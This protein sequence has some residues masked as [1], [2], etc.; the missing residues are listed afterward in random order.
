M[1][2]QAHFLVVEIVELLFGAVEHKVHVLPL[3]RALT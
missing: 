3:L 1:E 2:G